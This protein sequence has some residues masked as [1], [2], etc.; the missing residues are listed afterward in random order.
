MLTE[1]DVE[2]IMEVEAGEGEATTEPDE[3]EQDT[4]DVARLFNDLSQDMK[5]F[6]MRITALKKSIQKEKK[7]VL[8]LLSC[9]Q[10]LE[11]SF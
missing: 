5:E 1:T 7:K 2:Y 10:L 3:D 8:L 11:E 4:H 9:Q 6:G